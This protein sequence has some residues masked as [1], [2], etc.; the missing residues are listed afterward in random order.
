[1][2]LLQKEHERAWKRMKAAKSINDVQATI[3]LLQKARDSI[4]AG[5][6]SFF[7]HS[8]LWRVALT[9]HYCIDSTKAS[10]TLAKLQN[11]VKA[12]FDATNDSLK[13]THSSLNKYTKALDKVQGISCYLGFTKS[14]RRL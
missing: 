5:R 10:I 14:D 4:A 8:F 11:P 7:C 1:M 12:S 6:H 2:D 3:D 9:F 13:E